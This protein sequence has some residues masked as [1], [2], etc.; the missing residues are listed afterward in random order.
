MKVVERAEDGDLKWFGQFLK[1]SEEW[2]TKRIYV[3][4]AGGT[5]RGRRN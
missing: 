4:E 2:L 1:M 3:S 5:R